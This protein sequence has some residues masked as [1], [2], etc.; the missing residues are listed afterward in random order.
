M[1]KQKG[2]SIAT[3][4]AMGPNPC[5]L[6]SKQATIRYPS[7]WYESSDIQCNGTQLGYDPCRAGKQTFWPPTED[8]DLYS[9]ASAMGPHPCPA[10]QVQSLDCV[11][12]KHCTAQA[13]AKGSNRAKLNA[14]GPNPCPAHG[15]YSIPKQVVS[16]QQYPMQ[17]DPTWVPTCA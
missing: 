7:R 4:S 2:I 15:N 8:G 6:L 16:K 9:T 10:D 13:L 11:M 1:P 5:T 14:M 17:W 12:P 3:F